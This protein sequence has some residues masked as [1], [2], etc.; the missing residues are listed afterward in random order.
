VFCADAVS[1]SNHSNNDNVRDDSH[2]RPTP[3]CFC[4]ASLKVGVATH[5]RKT[6]TVMMWLELLGMEKE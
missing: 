2:F 4:V 1:Q 6:N 3:A 5:K